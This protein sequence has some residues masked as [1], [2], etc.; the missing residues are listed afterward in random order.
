MTGKVELTIDDMK[1]LL[2]DK[3]H[4]SSERVS[5]IFSPKSRLA[6]W[7][8]RK[9]G[10][11]TTCEIETDDQTALICKINGQEQEVEIHESRNCGGGVLRGCRDI[12]GE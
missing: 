12:G 8:I 10:F 9:R 11:V 5:I 2:A 4:T 3:F 6:M 7:L 1:S